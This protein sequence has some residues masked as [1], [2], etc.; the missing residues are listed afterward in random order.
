MRIGCSHIPHTQRHTAW[1]IIQS[2]CLQAI[3][4]GHGVVRIP[5]D[6]L[7]DVELPRLAELAPLVAER[8]LRCVVHAPI[9]DVTT[10]SPWLQ[11]CGQY[12]HVLDPQQGTIV[13]H[14]TRWDAT[15]S[16]WFAR[17]YTQIEGHVAVEHTHQD[18]E[19]LLATLAP[20]AV[21]IVFDW[22]H[23]HM[24]APWP[25][26]VAAAA[27]QCQQS[28]GCIRPLVHLSSPATTVQHQRPG[29]HSELLDVAQICTFLRQLRVIGGT[30]CD[31]EVEAQHSFMA[32]QGLLRYIDQHA[33]DLASIIEHP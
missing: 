5:R 10:L 22:L 8:G 21:P 6:V 14:L 17:H 12:L 20:Y 7:T 27:W 30:V 9:G 13:M 15:V 3:M 28:W 24:Q 31:F 33:P 23:Y 2:C 16:R 11:Q 26:D 32:C 4:H 29:T 25:Y 19:W 18:L 1:L